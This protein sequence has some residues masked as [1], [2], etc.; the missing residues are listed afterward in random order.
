MR[1]KKF[2][3]LPLAMAMMVSAF[4]GYVNAE[5]STEAVTLVVGGC[6]D[7]DA[8]PDNYQTYVDMITRFEEMYPY[9]TVEMDTYSYA[10]DT[11]MAKAAAGQLP[12]VNYVPLTEAQK[13]GESGYVVELTDKLEE[14]GYLDTYK[15]EVLDIITT[16]DGKIYSQCFG[17]NK[18][19]LIVNMTVIEEAGLLNEDGTFDAPDTWEELAVM[20]SEIKAKTGK[21]GL[22]FPTMNNAG[23]WHFVSLAYSYG[24]EFVTQNEDGT[25][26]ASFNTPE[27]VEALQFVYDL[28][29]KY[30]ALDDNSF[31]DN[32][33]ARLLVG[34]GQAAMMQAVPVISNFKVFAQNGMLPEE[35]G[36][37]AIPAG[38]EGRRALGGGSLH[39]FPADITDEEL[40]A[41]FKWIEFRG[42]GHT[43]NDDSFENLKA[44][45]ERYVSEGWGVSPV[46]LDSSYKSGEYVERVNELLGEVANLEYAQ[47]AEY[48]EDTESVVVPEPGIYCQELYAI[49]DGA[50]QEV[51][52]NQDADV[53]QLIADAAHDFQVNYLDLE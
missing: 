20:A 47:V 38:P 51:I 11:F 6:P 44:N 14:L 15:D 4:G 7:K 49:L 26:S 43:L 53:E 19:G 30:D 52:T 13:I 42:Y 17:S 41:A 32:A 35:V 16:E 21:A 23:G 46:I 36:V 1:V 25:W 9:I 33:Q 10:S 31:I 12:H 37:Y 5:E 22:S 40:D 34:S 28:K 50:I 18:F 27:A 29:W 45:Y 48:V 24:V 39:V 2:M 3:A 8:D